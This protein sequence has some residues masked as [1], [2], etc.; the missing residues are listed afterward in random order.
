MVKPN[1]PAL[2]QGR[3]V[4]VDQGYVRA[5]T[6]S[7]ANRMLIEAQR[8]IDV[9]RAWAGGVERRRG[10]ILC[11]RRATVPPSFPSH[12]AGATNSNDDQG[13]T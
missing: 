5:E 1:G 13:E 8:G 6:I 10:H 4:Q 11:E 2:A 3:P 7:A 12:H 9:G